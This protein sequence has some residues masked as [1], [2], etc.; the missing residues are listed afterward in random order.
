MPARIRPTESLHATPQSFNL[1]ESWRKGM[2]SRPDLLRVRTVA[3]KQER[4]VKY[5][6]NQRLPQFD[7]VG[8]VGYVG[9]DDEL[10][11]AFRQVRRTEN[12][13]YSYG[14]Q[15]TVPLGNVG[16]RNAYKA[17]KTTY[18]QQLLEVKKAEQGVLIQIENSIAGARTSLE[19]VEAT[20][21][22][23]AYAED[24]L[25]AEEMKLEKGK[26]TSYFVL[27]LQSKL[28]AARSAEIKALAD[29][30]IALAQVAQSEGSTL[31][32]RGV[33]LKLR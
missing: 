24:A 8:D 12:S 3:E 25:K 9:S 17:A 19:R 31:E 18:E 27:D 5:Q 22:A 32:R 13:Y 2:S 23:R 1:Q 11:S 33:E 28:T 20:R 6:R 14:V 30:N 29:Y 26:S 16:P 15:L 4:Q 7:L 10:S 21:Q